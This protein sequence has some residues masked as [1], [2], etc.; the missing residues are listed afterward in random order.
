MMC[1]VDSLG[2]KASEKISN[3][4]RNTGAIKVNYIS[5]LRLPMVAESRFRDYFFPSS[6]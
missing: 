1:R 5:L 6:T 2:T 4:Q 3:R